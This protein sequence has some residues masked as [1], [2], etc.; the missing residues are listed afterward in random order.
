LK[1]AE[2]E[3]AVSFSLNFSVSPCSFHHITIQITK[4]LN[5]TLESPN[6]NVT[7]TVAVSDAITSEAK[8]IAVLTPKPHHI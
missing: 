2:P 3:Y 1:V 6:H 5:T 7:R 8:L 4:L